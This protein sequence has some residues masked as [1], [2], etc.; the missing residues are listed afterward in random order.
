MLERPAQRL[1]ERV[2]TRGT[3][4]EAVKEVTEVVQSLY[5]GC[6]MGLEVGEYFEVKKGGLRLGCVMFP[7]IFNIFWRG[8]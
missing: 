5:Y 7:W 2:Y 6:R 8:E 4:S 3:E 1:S